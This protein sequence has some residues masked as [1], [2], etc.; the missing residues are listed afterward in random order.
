MK[1]QELP[2]TDR[3]DKLHK[4]DRRGGAR[5]PKQHG[6][7]S[8][9]NPQHTTPVWKPTGVFEPKQGHEEVIY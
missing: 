2:D 8:L 6:K 7:Y 5:E 1:Y 4:G 9:R 3:S